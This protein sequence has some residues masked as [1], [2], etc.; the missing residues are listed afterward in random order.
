M[1]EAFV[2]SLQSFA[3]HQVHNQLEPHFSAHRG[4]AKNAS[5]VEQANTAHLQQVGQELRTS[6]LNGVLVDAKQVNR[7][8]GHQPVAARNQ[9]ESQLA[10]AQARLASNQ[11]AHAQD[12]HEHP[13][14]GGTIGKMLGQVGAQH[15]NDKSRRAGGGKHRDLGAF[16]H[17]DQCIR[18][19]LAVSKHQHGRLERHDAADAPVAILLRGVHEVGDF[20]LTQ[21]LQAVG[22]YVVEVAHQIGPGAGGAYR[23]FVKTAL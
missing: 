21:N 7:V 19:C 1:G 18:C 11:N 6:A 17:R 22:M 16:A 14:H 8:I 15:I 3:T 4:F 23:N 10:L 20:S 9:L 2:V 13:V 5:N 12:V